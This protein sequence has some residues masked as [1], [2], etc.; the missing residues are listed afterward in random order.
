MTSVL[1][2]DFGHDGVGL[3][4]WSRVRK[5]RDEGTRDAGTKGRRDMLLSTANNTDC[6]AVLKHLWMV[7]K[8]FFS[9]IIWSLFFSSQS[10]K[11]NSSAMWQSSVRTTQTGSLGAAEWDNHK[12]MIRCPS[13]S[14]H[15]SVHP[16]IPPLIDRPDLTVLNLRARLKGKLQSVCFLPVCAQVTVKESV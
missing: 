14:I 5:R 12:L 9:I 10:R 3:C 13:P 1:V 15:S 2:W 6:R 11:K 8:S 4:P 16:S 7:Q